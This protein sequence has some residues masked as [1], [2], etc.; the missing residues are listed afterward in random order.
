[1]SEVLALQ[2]S[3]IASEKVNSGNEKFS[4]R[5]ALICLNKKLLY[6]LR[7]CEKNMSFFFIVSMMGNSGKDYL[8][9][10]IFYYLCKIDEVSWLID[11][12]WFLSL[13]FLQV[14][15]EF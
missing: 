5:N 9:D 4:K 8:F 3:I 2:F 13:R 12:N 6:E 11:E 15:S 1:M 14:E 7:Q 10:D